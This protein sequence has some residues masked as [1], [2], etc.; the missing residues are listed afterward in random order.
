MG[1]VALIQLQGTIGRVARL[2]RR[3]LCPPRRDYFR[4]E[5]QHIGA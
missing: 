1:I 5:Q 4:G 3:E 2:A